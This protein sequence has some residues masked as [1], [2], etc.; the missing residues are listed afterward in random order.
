MPQGSDPVLFSYITIVD[1][2]G[3]RA[4]GFVLRATH[5]DRNC[6]RKIQTRHKARYLGRRDM[7]PRN[8]LDVWLPRNP[9]YQAAV[10][11]RHRR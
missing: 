1:K 4:L 6:H 5:V 9:R 8:G 7:A 2:G 3:H 10:P 11:R